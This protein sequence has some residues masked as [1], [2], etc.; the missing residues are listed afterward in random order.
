M[1]KNRC[2]KRITET[3]AKR[4][5]SLSHPPPIAHAYNNSPIPSLRITHYASTWPNAPP[6][7]PPSHYF[8]QTPQSNS[9][10]KKQPTA[11][12]A[13]YGRTQLKQSSVKALAQN[14]K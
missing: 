13:I 10:K 2:A 4:G 8:P 6:S 1:T 7:N 9:S 14:Q 3:R 11:K 5:P 12:P